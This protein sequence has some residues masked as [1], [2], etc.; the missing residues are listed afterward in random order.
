MRHL[1]RL[2]LGLIFFAQLAHAIPVISVSADPS[3]SH[4]GEP[5][6]FKIR[7]QNDERDPVQPPQLP[8]LTDWE[9]TNASR[10]EFPTSIIVNGKIRYRYQGEFTYVLKPLRKGTLKIP[11]LTVGIGTKSYQTDPMVVIV[12]Q[13]PNGA[14]TRPRLGQ[15]PQAPP[16]SPPGFDPDED[17][18]AD[19]FANNAP[20]ELPPIDQVPQ[21][22]LPASTRESFFLRAEA[23][24]T[25]VYQGE[26]IVLSYALYQKASANIGNAEISKFPDFKGFLKEELLIPKN[27]TRTP[28]SLHGEPYFRSEILR[29]A[30]FPLKSGLLKIEPMVFKA[31]SVTSPRD[32]LQNLM[33][34]QLPQNLNGMNPI[35]MS[36]A[37][38][39]LKILSKPLP[40]A[41]TGAS[42][43]G[44]V[45]QFKMDVK[46]P[47]GTLRAEQPFTIQ[48]TIA[49]RGN[50]K[51]I[52]EPQLKLPKEL[53]SFQTKNSYEFNED[54]T[55]YKTFEYLINP[56]AGGKFLIDPLIWSY[57]DPQ[58]G[59]YVTLKG[60]ALE[61]NIEGPSASP[62]SGSAGA[63]PAPPV[64]TF[65]APKVGVQDF[66]SLSSIDSSSFIASP[67][68]W[69][70]QAL[71]YA[72][73]ALLLWRR[74]QADNL[75]SRYRASPWERTEKEIFARKDWTKK[76]LSNLVDQWIR[77]RLAGALGDSEIHSE[78]SRD[79]ISDALKRR[80]G[81]EKSAEMDKL[82]QLW[83][84]MDLYRFAGSQSA[85]ERSGRELFE[86][87]RSVIEALL[88][89]RKA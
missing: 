87:S 32:I 15:R 79:E 69:I 25:N 52:E 37:S 86:K 46:G 53:E 22:S 85:D 44:G 4:N 68:I 54:A 42:F 24:K 45:G 74:R 41:P 55:G 67:L 56:H 5:V 82:K 84:R 58:S 61:L 70:A 14:A 39:E 73:A 81:T 40:A 12:D 63:N 62:G 60:E 57:F 76:E 80:T 10:A 72:Y 51:A 59:K 66:D 77:E 78:S 49:G 47:T 71:L 64:A 17:P 18:F 30:V 36:K 48:V 13:L 20:E 23:S 3:Q 88:Q 1:N 83:E 27:F 26:L 29:Y 75:A 19:P 31:D 6:L 16:L 50:V 9:V 33:R 65:S 7:V 8:I 43:T 35:P 11:S 21:Q 34:G 2:C 89:N 28:V 38:E